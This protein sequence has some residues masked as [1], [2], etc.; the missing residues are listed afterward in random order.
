VTELLKLAFLNIMGFRNQ[1]G[2]NVFNLLESQDIMGIAESWAGLEAYKVTG[3]TSCFQGRC[4]TAK[5]GR[6]PEGLA[7]CIADISKCVTE[8]SAV[9]KEFTGRY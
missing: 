6:N 7:V 1:L 5:C 9:M 2:N 8:I 3:Y 4:K